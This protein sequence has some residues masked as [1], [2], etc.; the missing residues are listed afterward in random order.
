MS[1]LNISEC[2]KLGDALTRFTAPPVDDPSNV[3]FKATHMQIYWT[4]FTETSSTRKRRGP[5]LDS[6]IHA[7]APSLETRLHRNGVH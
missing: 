5:G 7:S 4:L 3:I 6:G 1:M 2:G